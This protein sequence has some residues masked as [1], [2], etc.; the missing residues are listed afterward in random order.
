MS[1]QIKY[2]EQK[3]QFETDSADLFNALEKGEKIIVL[4]VRSAEAFGREHIP[5]SVNIPYRTI[6]GESAA[7][8]DKSV[9]YISY[10]DGLG[11]NASTKGALKM[12]EL[13]FEV[14]E[15]IG[16][17]DWWRKD[18]YETQGSNP[19]KGRIIVCDC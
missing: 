17:L 3:L 9:Q 6:T 4:D 10:C 13:G 5:G 14:K 1:T 12:A 7:D 18:G 19:S 11:C 8:M 2:Y 16:G 15:L